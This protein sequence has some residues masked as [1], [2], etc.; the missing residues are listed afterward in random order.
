MVFLEERGDTMV[1][2]VF[3]YGLLLVILFWLCWIGLWVWPQ[4]QAATGQAHGQPAMRAKTRHMRDPKPFPGLTTKPFCAAWEH[5]S[6]PAPQRLS[7]PDTPHSTRFSGNV[8]SPSGSSCY[9]NVLS[10][11]CLIS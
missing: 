1:D 2:H 6:P 4:R 7:L 3:F 10:P 8:L 5:A 11:S 9:F